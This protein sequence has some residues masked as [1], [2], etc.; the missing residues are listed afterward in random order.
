LAGEI[1]SVAT[2]GTVEVRGRSVTVDGQ[3]FLM[4]GVCYA[5]NPIGHSGE[6]APNGDF[7]TTHWRAVYA[8]DLPLMRDMGV[9]CVRVYGWSPAADHDDF[10]DLAWN[11]GHRPIHVLINR[12][13]DPGT[14]WNSPAAVAALQGE[15]AGIATNAMHHPGTLG[16]VIGNELN[17][18]GWNPSLGSLWAA[19]NAVAGEIRRHDT[20]HLVTTALSDSGLIGSIAARNAGM[21]NLNAWCVQVYRGDSFKTLF[22]DYAAASGKPLFVTEFGLDAYDVRS[23]GEYADNAAVQGQWILKLWNELAANS[24]VASGGAVF[25]WCDEWWK[26]GNSALHSAG[27]WS[28]GAFPDGQA[29]EEWWGIH[30]VV[31]GSPNAVEPRAAYGALRGA[32]WIPSPP[33][34]LTLEPAIGTNA[35]GVGVS[36]APG[37]TQVLEVS[38][39]LKTWT[40]VRTNSGPFLWLDTEA[41]GTSHRFFRAVTQP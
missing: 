9:N 20:N 5:P 22:A 28:N 40:P 27:G 3:P 26:A 15:W 34:T 38:E 37:F 12:W 41:A 4:K 33:A 18:A 32:W 23:G 8:R 2:A 16:Y 25:E 21:T 31:A 10:L 13:I 36:G 6:Q 19:L 29:D 17:G 35:L 30:R 11:G 14:D 7:F 24:A 39:T 1:A